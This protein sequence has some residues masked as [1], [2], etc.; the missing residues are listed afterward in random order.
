MK[1]KFASSWNSSKQ[2]RKQR[3]FR[4]NA[5]LHIKQKFA[6]S[7]LSPELRKKYG[8]RSVTVRKGDE[9]KIMRGQFKSRKGK[10]ERV[11]LK[12]TKVYI[13]GIELTK[14]D[15][16]KTI[17]PLQPSNLMII[18]ANTDDKRRFSSN[19]QTQSVAS[20]KA[21]E[22]PVKKTTA[23]KKEKSQNKPVGGAE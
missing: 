23:V 16:S 9:V 8:T 17:Y 19:T 1:K 7:H 11:D 15:G 6:S 18:S 20:N 2:P 21:S 14:K 3:K 10:V 12:K 22:Q 13:T 4:Y 5:P